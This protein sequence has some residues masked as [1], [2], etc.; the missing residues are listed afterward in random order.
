MTNESNLCGPVLH[1]PREELGCKQILDTVGRGVTED[2]LSINTRCMIMCC[3][4]YCLRRGTMHSLALPMRG[5][6]SIAM[7]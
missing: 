2:I 4:V 5:K 7:Y 6:S 1:A 3:N